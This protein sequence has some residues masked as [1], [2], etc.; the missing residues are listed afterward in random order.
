MSSLL[1]TVTIGPS[2]PLGNGRSLSDTFPNV[3]VL[4]N[5]LLKNSLTI[6]SLLLLILLIVGGIQF[7]M[8]AGSDDPKKAQAAKSMITDALIGFVIV[9]CAYFIIQIIEVVTG[10]NILN[11]GF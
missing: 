5:I 2:I 8:G 7:I 4:L 1:A 9:F 11:P 3:G 6:I 10:L